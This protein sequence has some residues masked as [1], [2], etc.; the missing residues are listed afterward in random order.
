MARA[1]K[2]AQ[3]AAELGQA[4]PLLPR[5]R[6]ALGMAEYREGHYLGRRGDPGRRVAIVRRLAH[7]E[8]FA[9]LPR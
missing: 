9:A 1:L 4:D 7:R 2:L 3:R 5:F 8:D 6:M